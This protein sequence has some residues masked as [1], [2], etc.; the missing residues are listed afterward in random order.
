MLL[1]QAQCS[2]EPLRGQSVVCGELD[3]GVDPELRF[4]GRMADVNVRAP[5]LAG[6]EEEP[7]ASI[8]KDRRTHA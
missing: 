3:A 1:D 6:E 8:S 4:P 7:I 2:C 5:L